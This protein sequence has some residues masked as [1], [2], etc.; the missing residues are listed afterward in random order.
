MVSPLRSRPRAIAWTLLLALGLTSFHSAGPAPVL[1]PFGKTRVFGRV[2]WIT[3]PSSGDN[4][5]PSLDLRI[6]AGHTDPAVRE[7]RIEWVVPASPNPDYPGKLQA[8]RQRMTDDDTG[9][10][11]YP[12]PILTHEARVVGGEIQ[13]RV[14]LKSK[15]PAT[16]QHE[17]RLRLDDEWYPIDGL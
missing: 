3:E 7:V 13:V 14:T 17:E 10:L 6:E 9:Y 12:D 16:R 1:M 4:V 15:G 5:V 8:R 11:W 2:R